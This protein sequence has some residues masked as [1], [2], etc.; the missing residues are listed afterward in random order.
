M[1]LEISGGMVI[2]LIIGFAIGRYY[3]GN[4]TVLRLRKRGYAI[5]CRANY[6]GPS[7]YY[8]SYN[9]FDDRLQ[10]ITIIGNEFTVY[11]DA[12]ANADA[13]YYAMALKNSPI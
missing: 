6:Y 7:Y 9:G 2:G 4:E 11:D 12:V 8:F 10:P 3:T 13:H 5:K 1:I